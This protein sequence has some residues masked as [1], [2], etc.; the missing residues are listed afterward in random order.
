MTNAELGI[1]DNPPETIYLQREGSIDYYATWS[2]EAIDDDDIEYVRAAR[3]NELISD[4]ELLQL[5]IDQYEKFLQSDGVMDL[6]IEWER[7][8]RESEH[9]LPAPF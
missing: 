6:F 2:V 9:G 7:P 5:R 8:A 3:V 4:N 1:E